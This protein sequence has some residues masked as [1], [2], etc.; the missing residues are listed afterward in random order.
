MYLIWHICFGTPWFQQRYT[1]F[2]PKLVFFCSHY[3]GSTPH[4]VTVTIYRDRF[5]DFIK[6]FFLQETT[7]L[8]KTICRLMF[9]D[10]T[11]KHNSLQSLWDN[12]VRLFGKKMCLLALY[13]FEYIDMVLWNF[14]ALLVFVH[15][16][17]FALMIN[18]RNTSHMP[19]TNQP[20]NQPTTFG[21]PRSP[22]LYRRRCLPW[23]QA[24][25]LQAR[26]PR[27][28]QA[29]RFPRRRIFGENW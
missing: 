11:S 21:H 27:R 6:S 5:T 4:Q 17:T 7:V 2:V 12:H 14:Y 1:F 28:M 15:S 13:M 19:Y 9:K 24:R 29:R 22:S 26:T 16:C 23:F 18:K 3:L 10:V 25:M 8:P 20:T